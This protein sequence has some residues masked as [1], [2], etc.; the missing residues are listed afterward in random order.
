MTVHQQTTQLPH[1]MPRNRTPELTRETVSLVEQVL[2]EVVRGLHAQV[3]SQPAA[4]AGAI[5]YESW[6]RGARH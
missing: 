6:L 5:E 2:A 4:D 1:P 3:S